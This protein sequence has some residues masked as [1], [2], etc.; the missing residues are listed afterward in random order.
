MCYGD[1]ISP[2]VFGKNLYHII[3]YKPDTITPTS[4]L[5]ADRSYLLSNDRS[6]TDLFLT[7]FVCSRT[8]SSY[9]ARCTYV[10]ISRDPRR[11]AEGRGDV[12]QS[13]FGHQRYASIGKDC[14]KS[15]VFDQSS[16]DR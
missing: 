2:F 16:E 8:Q 3:T 4:I 6:N 9:S 5:S 15:W 10:T 1:E 12:S 14:G 11:Y 13:V 7:R